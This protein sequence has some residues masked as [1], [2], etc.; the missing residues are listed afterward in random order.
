MKPGQRLVTVL[1]TLSVPAD[2]DDAATLIAVAAD[3]TARTVI[4]TTGVEG[5]LPLPGG[6]VMRGR[7]ER[8]W[9]VHSVVPNAAILTD[10]AGGTIWVDPPAPRPLR[11]P[12]RDQRGRTSPPTTALT[13]PQLWPTAAA[14]NART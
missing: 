10:L 5:H 8:P 4:H 7:Q 3:C 14:A 9:M 13:L 2:A 1:V 6:T 11:L 12:H